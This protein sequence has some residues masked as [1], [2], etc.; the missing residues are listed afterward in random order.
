M[1]IPLNKN[2]PY[3]FSSIL[4]HKHA[5]VIEK[6]SD[7]MIDAFAQAKADVAA[8]RA[9]GLQS[10]LVV[11]LLAT[12]QLVGLIILI[13]CSPSLVYSASDV[14]LAQELA[15]RAALSLQNARLFNEAQRAV[16]TR[17]D[18]LAIVSH[19]LKNPVTSMGLVAH[20][21]RQTERMEAAQLRNA[22][23]KIERGAQKMLLLISDLLDFSKIRSG[24]FSIELRDAALEDIMAAAIE[25]S[26]SLAEAKRQAIELNLQSGLPRVAADP[27]RI[28]Q[29]MSNLLGN[30]IKFSP[31]G[32]K[33]IVS[34]RR[35]GIE[36]VV[37]VT[38][39]GPGIPPELLPKVFDR[40]WQAKESQ[41]MG[42]G[43][44]L[45]IAKGIIEAHHG[46]I[47]AESKL[48][49]QTS[50]FFTL[51]LAD[52]ARERPDIAA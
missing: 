44:G 10:A 51:P 43:L 26:K 20:V 50:F 35:Q 39:Q 2:W 23:A 21:L 47:W 32:G 48:G 19:D 13:S 14:R 1:R 7:E 38:D 45:S 37:S 34:A 8:F 27:N 49:K 17:D 46:K 29:L 4:E 52:A 42:S 3:L 5:V 33:I 28:A 24:T 15:Q 12:G 18:I 31:E 9:A 40:F 6:L 22:A 11:P 41:S 30:A 16:K 36:A 25:S